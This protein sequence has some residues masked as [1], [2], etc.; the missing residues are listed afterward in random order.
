MQN[1]IVI[2]GKISFA[3]KLVREINFM[4]LPTKTLKVINL[5]DLFKISQVVIG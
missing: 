5:S 1:I 3:L 4:L 2:I